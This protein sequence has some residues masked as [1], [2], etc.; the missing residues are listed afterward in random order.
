MLILFFVLII[1][2]ISLSDACDCA[3]PNRRKAYCKSDF[4]GTI[5][6]L[7][8]GSECGEM[9]ICYSVDII[10]KFRDTPITP[11]SLKTSSD[12]ASCGVTLT[13]GN[14]YF[15]ITNSIDSKVINLN[16]CQIS[17]DWTGLTN[18]ELK[19]KKQMYREIRCFR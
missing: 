18:F 5:R 2:S 13:Q 15:V 17:E 14:I 9:Q 8:N 1:S 10:E 4:V 12:S 16:L 7:S 19:K 3:A 11:R 6:V